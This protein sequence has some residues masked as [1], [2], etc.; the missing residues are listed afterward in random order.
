MDLA[1]TQCL[2]GIVPLFRPHFVKCIEQQLD[3]L[4]QILGTLYL[5]QTWSPH[6]K[7]IDRL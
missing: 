1:P 4:Q 6:S 2:R 5:H 7:N 3:K